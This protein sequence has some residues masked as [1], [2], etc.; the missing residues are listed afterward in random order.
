LILLFTLTALAQVQPSLTGVVRDAKTGK[1]L[2]GTNISIIGAGL[3][4]CA[5]TDGRFEFYDL[6]ACFYELKISHIGYEE[7]PKSDVQIREGET[8]FLSIN[9]Q[10]IAIPLPPVTVLASHEAN[11]STSSATVIQ[12]RE[13][14]NHGNSDITEVLKQV[15]GVTVYEEGGKGGRKTVSIRG[16]RPDQVVVEVDGIS[17]N[18]AS[19]CAVDLSQFSTDQIER[20]EIVRGGALSAGSSAMG[21]LV[22]IFMR[23]PNLAQDSGIMKIA[24]A[25]GSFGYAEG[26]ARLQIPL[27]AAAVE[28]YLRRTQSEGNFTYEERGCEK[29]RINNRYER[30]LGQ[31]SGLW[32]LKRNLQW[33]ILLS[34]D[35]RERGS[36][37][38][39]VQ[40][41][42]PEAKLTEDPMR[43]TSSLKLQCN[44]F[45]AEMANFFSRQKREYRSPREQYDPSEH[46]TYYHAPVW[47]KDED[48]AWG[49][50]LVGSRKFRENAIGVREISGGVHFRRDEYESKDFLDNGVTSNRTL[51]SVYRN[52]SGIQ[53]KANFGL[54]QQAPHLEWTGEAQLDVIDQTDLA[55]KTY[56]SARGRISLFPL[57]EGE[58]SW[59]VIV[60]GSYGSSYRLPSFVSLFLVESVFA[61]GNKSLKPERS[62]DGDCGI[63]C[64][65]RSEGQGWFHSWESSVDAFW[66]RIEDMIVWHRNFRGQYFPDNVAIGEIKGIE[67][68]TKISFWDDLLAL[69]GNGTFQSALNK[70]PDKHYYNKVLPLQPE[71]QGGASADWSP[72]AFVFSLGLRSMGRRYT[73]DDNTD[74]LSTAQ[75]DLRPFTVFDASVEWHKSFRF[76]R[77]TWRGLVQNVADESYMIVERS[78]M[79]GRSFELQ[80]SFER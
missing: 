8:T 5:D 7:F 52:T 45:S 59:N 68:S 57:P 44:R 18:A 56:E 34:L 33:Q 46:Q 19:G 64:E 73:T 29:E 70:T 67:L 60:S 28:V 6:P 35:H 69:K 47:T 30:W 63:F 4:T 58:S 16:C 1:G 3:G 48:Q 75:R 17:M 80:F 27:S 43:V 14:E 42:T 22:R 50:S 36:P 2:S 53:A 40:S 65:Y 13:L 39:I 76:G 77:M 25:G 62:R 10:P 11:A 54:P 78:P 38:L 26:S 71:V 79:P 61:L 66:N 21:G 24:A 51:G 72:L 12:G 31:A 20:V 37:G 74:P 9:L 49:G 41:P 23:K 32:S 55:S 15:S